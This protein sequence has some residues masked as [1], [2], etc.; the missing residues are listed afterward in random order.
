MY[1][2]PTSRSSE[3]SRMTYELWIN[4]VFFDETRD[5]SLAFAWFDD[6][7]SRSPGAVRL[8]FEPDPEPSS[9][10]PRLFM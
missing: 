4:G 8:R 2:R 10:F 1:I 9:L 6:W 3:V 7:L 5:H